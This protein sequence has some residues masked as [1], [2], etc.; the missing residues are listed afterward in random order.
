[1]TMKLR[2]IGLAVD[3]I[4]AMK[5]FYITYFGF[6][7]VCEQ[8]ERGLFIEN[9]LDQKDV[10]VHVVKMMLPGD[11]CLLELL[12][13]KNIGNKIKKTLFNTGMTHFAL[14]VSDVDSF[15]QRLE[16]TGLGSLSQPCNSPDGRARVVFCR[17]PEGNFIELVE[18]LKPGC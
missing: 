8:K 2:H 14:T 10:E 16:E 12:K 18:G 9:I 1:M 6:E 3:D 5:M 11:G 17:D 15:Y 13:F 4:E 7:I